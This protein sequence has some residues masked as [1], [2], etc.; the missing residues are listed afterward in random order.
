MLAQIVAFLA[1][2]GFLLI[3]WC[4]AGIQWQQHRVLLIIE[5]ILWCFTVAIVMKLGPH[6]KRKPSK[7]IEIA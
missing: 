6:L 1:I 7:S 3:S 4:R 2:P 5:S